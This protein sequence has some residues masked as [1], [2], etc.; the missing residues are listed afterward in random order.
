MNKISSNFKKILWEYDL[1]KLKFN[2]DIVINRVMSFGDL[3]DMDLLVKEV[4]YDFL[5]DYFRKNYTNL[6]VK[7]QK[8]WGLFFGIKELKIKQNSMYDQLNKPV[9]Q[10]SF[11]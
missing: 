6:D 10:R 3:E 4:G 1:T 2:D 11:R 8:L 5:K 9:F 7:S